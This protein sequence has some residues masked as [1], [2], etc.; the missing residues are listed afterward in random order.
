[1]ACDDRIYRFLF[2]HSD[3]RGEVVSLGS[4]CEEVL[5]HNAHLPE[6]ARVLLGEFVA[7]VTLLSATLKFDGVITL[8]CRGEGPMSMIMAEC[9]RHRTVR[10]VAHVDIDEG[11]DVA[12]WDLSQWLPGAVLAIIIEP[13]RGERYQ[14]IVPLDQATLQTCLERYFAQSE[15]LPTRFWLASDGASCG[16]VMLQALPQQ[17]A[18]QEQNEERWETLVHLAS[19]I[20]HD[21]LVSLPGEEV[22]HRL[23]HEQQPI[24]YE[25]DAVAFACS[26]SRER[27]ANALV[28]LGR[29]EVEGMLLEQGAI[30]IDCQFCNAHYVFGETD[31]GAIFGDSGDTLH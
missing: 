8:Q 23:F 17:L 6:A 7:A 11:Q 12:E 27:S 25:P 21:E 20:K 31:L 9:S 26:C 22:I 24:V 19:T 3:I 1:M 28:S 14:G 2:E 15:Q 10:A 5:S 4:T 16:G 18:T 30:Q 29:A 13:E